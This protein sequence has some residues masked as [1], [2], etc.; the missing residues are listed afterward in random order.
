MLKL[1]IVDDS[2]II[3][4]R[5]ERIYQGSNTIKVVGKA[6]NGQMAIQ[7]AKEL[8]PDIVTMDLTMPKIDGVAC[9]VKLKEIKPSINILVVSALSDKAT[10]IAALSK[11]ARGFIYKPFSDKDLM[12]A[13]DKIMMNALK[14]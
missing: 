12:L 8:D 13:I 3:R 14:V 1:L 10:G 2:N 9:I 4:S 11:G 6:V 5:I 7:L